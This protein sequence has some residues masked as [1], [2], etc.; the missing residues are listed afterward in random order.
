[1]RKY[2]INL[3]GQHGQRNGM[4]SSKQWKSGGV[5]PEKKKYH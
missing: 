5:L 1:M 2:I 4:D 3:L